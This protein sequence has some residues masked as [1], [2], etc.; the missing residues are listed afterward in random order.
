[1]AAQL[2]HRLQ[3]H[4]VILKSCTLVVFNENAMLVL[5]FGCWRGPAVV[6]VTSAWQNAAAATPGPGVV[7]AVGDFSPVVVVAVSCSQLIAL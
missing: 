2:G 6:C 1:M 5:D 3:V 4:P 7:A